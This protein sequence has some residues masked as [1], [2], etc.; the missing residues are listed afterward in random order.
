MRQQRWIELPSDA[1]NQA[2]SPPI[3]AEPSRI[4]IPAEAGGAIPALVTRFL[5]AAGVAG[6]VVWLLA[7]DFRSS[8]PGISIS[9]AA[10]EDA[11]RQELAK[12]GVTLDASWTVLSRID[13]QPDAMDRFV[14]QTAGKE[15][16]ARL[17]GSYL[18]PPNWVVR[19][20]RFEGDVA[21]RK[22]EYDVSVSGSG[23]V[24]EVAHALP[25]ARPAPSLSQEQAAVLARSVVP[26]IFATSLDDISDVS[27]QAEKHPSR[28]DWTFDFKDKQNF[29]LPEGEPRLQVRVQGD[30]IGDAKRYIHVSEEWARTERRRRDIPDHLVLVISVFTLGVI[31]TGAIIAAVRWSRRQPFSSRA[32]LRILAA[33]VV[34]N[35]INFANNWRTTTAQFDT[36]TPFAV[37]AALVV[38]FG[39]V[40]SAVIAATLGLLAGLVANDKPAAASAARRDWMSGIFLGCAITGVRT[41]A[42]NVA[43]SL[44]PSWPDFSNGGAVLP[45]LGT[46]LAPFVGFITQALLLSLVFY[47]IGRISSG[48]RRRKGWAITFFV[49]VGLMTSGARTIETIPSWLLSAGVVAAAL[50]VAYLAVLRHRPAVIIPTAAAVTVLNVLK[51]GLHLAYPSALAGSIG[52]SILIA[53]AAQYWLRRCNYH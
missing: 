28:T 50:L 18:E 14:W 3:A 34:L 10:A 7:S 49:A 2:W 19:F 42:L 47:A 5:G 24:Y 25:E 6:I 16:Y 53:L 4:E 32:F 11:A 15:V 17:M 27:A 13:A 38:I 48:F 51:E 35:V 22:E 40:S 52:A 33:V 37:Q 31:V 23:A 9:R 44:S 30:Q 39:V 12:R 41:I 45:L 8:V 26:Q 20:A 1:R 43:P 46:I 29:G 36:A 21:E